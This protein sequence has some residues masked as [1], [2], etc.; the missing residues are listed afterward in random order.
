[1][2]TI[3]TIM[4]PKNVAVISTIAELSLFSSMAINCKMFVGDCVGAGVGVDVG[5]GVGADV[6][7]DVGE[8]VGL[9]VNMVIVRMSL[10]SQAVAILF[11][12]SHDKPI[13]YRNVF[14]TFTL[15][16]LIFHP[17]RSWSIFALENM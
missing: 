4:Q 14:K 17:E 6:G 11:C 16:A 12:K 15:L 1:M 13:V 9:H 3:S 5:D 8:A 10:T 7:V 2:D